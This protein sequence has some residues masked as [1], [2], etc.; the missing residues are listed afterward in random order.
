MNN[1][2][3]ALAANAPANSWAEDFEHENGMYDCTCKTCEEIFMGHKRRIECKKC[4]TA[5][6]GAATGTKSIEM[7]YTNYRGE[8]SQRTIT[9]IGLRW[10]VSQWHQEPCW[11]LLAFDHGKNATREFALEDADFR[12]AVITET[13]NDQG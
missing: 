12:N 11:L 9:P 13:L 6:Q 5:T 7:F 3:K 10:S 4:A 2:K 1:F 8:T